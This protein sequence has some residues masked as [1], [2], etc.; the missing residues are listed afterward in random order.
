[1][2][3]ESNHLASKTLSKP[4]SKPVFGFQWCRVEQCVWINARLA[5]YC[6]TTLGSCVWYRIPGY[7][8]GSSQPGG[9]NKCHCHVILSWEWRLLNCP[10]QFQ[11]GHPRWSSWCD[12]YANHVGLALKTRIFRSWICTLPRLPSVLWLKVLLIV[13]A[14]HVTLIAVRSN[15]SLRDLT[16]F[17]ISQFSHTGF[18]DSK[19]IK[20]TKKMGRDK[21]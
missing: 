20:I 17:P 1:M 7:S 18:I 8:Q 5:A 6:W 4:E 3:C 19:N 2:D 10:C 16:R 9:L 21:G 14:L 12:L 11:M 13:W 15:D